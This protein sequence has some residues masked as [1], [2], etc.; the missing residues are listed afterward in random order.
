M[1]LVEL[2]EDGGDL[3]LAE[4]VVQRVVNVRRKNAKA[5]GGVAVDGERGEQAL[6]QLVAGDVANVGERAEFGDETGCPIGELFGV[7]VFEAVLKLGAADA[8]F[9]GEILNGLH[10]ERNAVHLGK[11]GLEAANDVGG[12]VHCAA[13]AA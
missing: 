13:R 5:G 6:V 4:S 11:F 9:D 2:R 8:V 3:A 7:H 10:E 1:I 12:I